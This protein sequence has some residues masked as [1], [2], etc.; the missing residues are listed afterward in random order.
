MDGTFSKAKAGGDGIGCRRAG[1]GVKNMI[2]VDAKGLPIAVNAV[3]TSRHESHSAFA[4][5]AF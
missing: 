5:E 4:S 1:K 2:I 3:S